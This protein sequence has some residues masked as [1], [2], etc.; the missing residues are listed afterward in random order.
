M[1]NIDS[2]LDAVNADIHALDDKQK[3]I[4]E[5]MAESSNLRLDMPNFDIEYIYVGL[6]DTCLH[7]LDSYREILKMTDLFSAPLHSRSLLF[8]FSEN[9]KKNAQTCLEFYDFLEH[10]EQQADEL[11]LSLGRLSSVI[12]NTDNML[13]EIV[14]RKSYL[15]MCSIAAKISD[16]QNDMP[17]KITDAES[18]LKVI[19]NTLGEVRAIVLSAIRSTER[20]VSHDLPDFAKQCEQALDATHHGKE[21]HVGKAI[22]IVGGF[23]NTQDILLREAREMLQRISSLSKSTDQTFYNGSS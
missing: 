5:I 23:R 12:R 15:R 11:S 8:S 9:E 2:M 18:E 19:E 10:I 20:F 21:L 4:I 6:N 16:K 17:S 22:R 14:E 13:S 7:V 3:A 1:K